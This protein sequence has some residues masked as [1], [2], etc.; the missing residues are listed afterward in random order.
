LNPAADYTPLSFSASGSAQSHGLMAEVLES[1]QIWLLPAYVEESEAKD[2][3]FD[4]EKSLFDRTREAK[5]KGAKALVFFDAYGSPY[6]PSFL[7]RSSFEELDIPVLFLGKE[8]YGRYVEPK[9]GGMEL[10]VN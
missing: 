10:R 2:A 1:D 5:D 4:W 9:S 7:P 6:P 8:A 3:H